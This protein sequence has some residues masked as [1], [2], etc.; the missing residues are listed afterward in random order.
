M[1]RWHLLRKWLDTD[2]V[3]I[4]GT[5]GSLA[6]LVECAKR[7]NQ[8]E[9]YRGHYFVVHESELPIFGLEAPAS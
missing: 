1:D 7:S 5:A 9:G 8:H 6:D 3:S 4:V 2:T